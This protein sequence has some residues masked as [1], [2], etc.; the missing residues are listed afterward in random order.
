MTIGSPPNVWAGLGLWYEPPVV[1]SQQWAVSW[2]GSGRP[3]VHVPLLAA[4][5]SFPNRK[6][7]PATDGAEARPV[8]AV[9]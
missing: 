4:P 2:S 9:G 8:S 3:D 1:D 7:L 6:L 5:Q